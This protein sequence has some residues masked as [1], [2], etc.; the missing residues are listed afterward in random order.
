M[1]APICLFT[2]NRPYLTRQTI[3][4]LQKNTLA[5]KSDLIIFSDGAK[6]DKAGPLVLLVRNYIHSVSGF[7]S[8]T[9]IESN[10][11]KGLANSIISG[12]TQIIERYEKIIVL[13]DDLVTSP[14]FLD[15]MNQALNFY[16]KNEKIFSISGYTLD[17]PSLKKTTKDYYLG[18]R[19]SSWGWGTWKDRWV[20]VDWEINDLSSLIWNPLKHLRFL[21]GGSDLSLMLWRQ[22]KG[23][24]DSW[25]VRWCYHQSKNDL[26]TVF[27][28][29]TK[30]ISLGFGDSATH[31]KKTNR[32]DVKLD[33][34]QQ[35]TF[36]FD[37]KLK[38]NKKI[39]RE[40]RKKFSIIARIKDKFQQ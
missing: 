31:T 40:F 9:V 22:K 17:L 28:S 30:L 16:E 27:P 34:S 25:A 24:I 36:I 8:V 13:E 21:R 33:D 38:I 4:A 2:Y 6:N 18:Y 37:F 20:N 5:H 3:E 32:F 15:F 11:N 35:N 39:V 12:V 23:I 29:K 19:A 10:R 26:L 7:K 1:L 14:N